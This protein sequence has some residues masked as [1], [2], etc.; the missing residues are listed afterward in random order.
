MGGRF[1]LAS[2]PKAAS[3][4]PWAL[5]RG[6]CCDEW[7]RSHC[8]WQCKY[9]ASNMWNWLQVCREKEFSRQS[10]EVPSH[11]NYSVFLWFTAPSASLK[12]LHCSAEQQLLILLGLPWD[13]ATWVLLLKWLA[14]GESPELTKQRALLLRYLKEVH[15]SVSQVSFLLLRFALPVLQSHSIME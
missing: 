5:Q 3:S 11:L 13:S 6:F 9:S 2:R 8:L 14:A 1:P 12:F 7:D 15:L 4:S 10:Q